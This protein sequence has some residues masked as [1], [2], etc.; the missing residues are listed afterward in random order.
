[1]KQNEFPSMPWESAPGFPVKSLLRVGPELA[2][3]NPIDLKE[4]LSC[5]SEDL[6]KLLRLHSPGTPH[7]ARLGEVHVSE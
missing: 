2:K 4:I 7:S 1:M 6:E 5:E 3:L